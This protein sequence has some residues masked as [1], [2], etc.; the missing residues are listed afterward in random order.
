MLL[1]KRRS[2]FLERLLFSFYREREKK[3]LHNKQ[4]PYNCE[5]HND[6]IDRF[7]IFAVLS[8]GYDF[9]LLVLVL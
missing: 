7:D 2:Y 3:S 1:L 6:N 5:K 9:V 8:P 4:L